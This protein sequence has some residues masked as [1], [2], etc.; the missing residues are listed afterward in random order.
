ML[1]I[2]EVGHKDN[3]VSSTGVSLYTH[4]GS[5][6]QAGKESRDLFAWATL[7]L[8]GEEAQGAP[9]WLVQPSY[10]CLPSTQATDQ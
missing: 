6:G 10:L 2:P 4:L 9:P 5:P 8:R 1:Q 3:T 7:W